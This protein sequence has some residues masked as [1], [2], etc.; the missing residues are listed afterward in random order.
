VQ[1]AAAVA[2]DERRWSRFREDSEV[3]LITSCAGRPVRVSA[4]TI[5]LLE[6]CLDWSAR[7]GGVF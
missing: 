5:D 7:T 6:S 2:D 3:S 4:A 1:V